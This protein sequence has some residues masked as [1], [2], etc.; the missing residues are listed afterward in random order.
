MFTRLPKIRSVFFA[1]VL[2]LCTTVILLG[3][4]Y[5]FSHWFNLP[6]VVLAYLLTINIATQ[7]GRSIAGLTASVTAFLL[8]NVFFI[9]PRGTLLINNQ[10][11]LL[12]LF[13]FLV[14][15][16]INSQLLGRAQTNQRRAET[17]ERDAIRFYEFSLELIGLRD[18]A[19]VAQLLSNRLR[20]ILNANQIEVTL[21]EKEQLQ[22]DTWRSGEAKNQNLQR[23][24]E[25]IASARG[26]MGE[27]CI[28]RTEMLSADEQR[29]VRTFAS[30][31]GLVL[32]RFRTAEA[33]S[34]AKVLEESD[35]LKSAL[36]ASVSHELRTPLATLRAGAESLSTGIVPPESQNGHELLSDMNDAAQHL[37]RLVNNMLDM[38][39][40][41]SGALNPQWEWNELVEIVNMAVTHLRSELGVHTLLIDVPDDLPLLPIDP[42]Q[43]DQVF[44]NLIS[45]SAK[46]APVGTC[47]QIIARVQDD[48][49]ALI[50]VINQSP[51]LPEEDLARI[52]DKFYRVTHADQVM[53]TG[54]GLSICKGIIEAHRGRIWASNLPGSTIGFVFNFTLP[55][56]WNGM[57]PKS[58]QIEL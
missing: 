55:L 56:K 30:E 19:T 3:F 24:H 17:R 52:F 28:M 38:T 39:R 21:F 57:L 18:N 22:P 48:S 51:V 9:E 54:L 40:I 20:S 8:L 11:D 41:E 27:I 2:T 34:R 25:P 1:V 47:I 36:L 32:E 10:T 5:L 16:L 15:A 37:T 49:F 29:V 44:T 14:I 13:I 58:P 4:S 31:A 26:S 23:M 7:V 42:V 53:G 33:E 6:I 43:I 35:R 12:V 50:Q 46:Y 45:N